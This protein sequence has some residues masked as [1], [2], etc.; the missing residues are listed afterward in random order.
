M[1]LEKALNILDEE[2]RERL[3]NFPVRDLYLNTGGKR[4]KG[5]AVAAGTRFDL[6]ISLLS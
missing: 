2:E 1:A 3:N 5:R 4:R 6:K